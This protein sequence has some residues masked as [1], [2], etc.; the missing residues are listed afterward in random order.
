[1]RTALKPISVALRLVFV[2]IGPESRPWI[3]EPR[4]AGKMTESGLM[5]RDSRLVKG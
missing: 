1:M 2:M 4:A 3:A 5:I